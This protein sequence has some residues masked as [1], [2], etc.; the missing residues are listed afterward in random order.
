MDRALVPHGPPEPWGPVHNTGDMCRDQGTVISRAWVQNQGSR[1]RPKSGPRTA[2]VLHR[3][4]EPWGPVHNTWDMCRDQGTLLRRAW[5][6]NQGP[7]PWSSPPQRRS[8]AGPPRAQRIH[9]RGPWTGPMVQ[10]QGPGPW[11]SILGT[12]VL[13]K[14]TEGRT[15]LDL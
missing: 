8:T 10:N 7:G 3:P 12:Y 6:Q 11:R 15:A 9:L 5:V 1:T 4:P 2:L 13:I 14:R